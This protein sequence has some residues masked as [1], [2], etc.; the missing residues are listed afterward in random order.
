MEL[1]TFKKWIYKYNYFRNEKW[2]FVVFAYPLHR[3]M[4]WIIDWIFIG[5]LL[6]IISVFILWDSFNS[7]TF[8]KFY[9]SLFARGIISLYHAI[10]WILWNWKTIW[11][12]FMGLQVVNKDFTKIRRYQAIWR[13]LWYLP[14]AML[15]NLPY[16]IM[17]FTKKNV[18]ISD[19]VAQT[20]VVYQN[21]KTPKFILEAEN[22]VTK[23]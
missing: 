4:S 18:A 21:K 8:E 2:E 19:L 1:K 11:K 6:L 7:E 5:I 16:L 3:L 14:H 20:Y 22:D 9:H 23:S 17:F 15:A 12:N 13:S 10:F